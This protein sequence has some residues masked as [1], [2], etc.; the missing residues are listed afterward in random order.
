MYGSWDMVGD[1][2]TDGK[3]DIKRWYPTQNLHNIEISSHDLL[4]KLHN[5][6]FTWH[7][8][9]GLLREAVE[10]QEFSAFPI[11]F[12]EKK[13]NLFSSNLIVYTPE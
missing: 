1:R 2:W 8:S 3:R 10:K 5:I 11:N 13:Q 7:R 6:D 9:E 12:F 4:Q